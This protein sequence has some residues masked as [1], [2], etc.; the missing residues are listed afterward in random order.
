MTIWQRELKIDLLWT[1]ELEED[2]MG[3]ECGVAHVDRDLHR[4]G[5]TGVDLCLH[6]A[7]HR[8]N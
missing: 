4:A 6:D 1:V 3:A 8:F 7:A 2:L 5:R